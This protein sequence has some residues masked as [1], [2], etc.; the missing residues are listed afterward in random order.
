MSCASA[1][2]HRVAD[3][4][5]SQCSGLT[6]LVRSGSDTFSLPSRYIFTVGIILEVVCSRGESLLISSC[7]ISKQKTQ[8][9]CLSLDNFL[10]PLS[11]NASEQVQSPL[12]HIPTQK[13][14]TFEFLSHDFM[15]LF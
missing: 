8:C 3:M 6:E 15:M 9:S 14:L 10:L 2:N 12:L 1:A 5:E 4:T 7:D 13:Q 11:K